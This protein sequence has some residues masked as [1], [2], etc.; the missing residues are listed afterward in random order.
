M[1]DNLDIIGRQKVDEPGRRPLLIKRTDGLQV[2][3]KKD[4]RWWVPKASAVFLLRSPRVDGSRSDAVHARLFTEL[5]VDALNEYSYD[6]SIARLH[7]DVAPQANA[8]MLSVTGYNDK[9]AVL[10][11]VV[12]EH[13]R[14][15]V[16]DPQ[17][18]ELVRDQLRQTYEN[19]NL[20]APSA[21]ASY[22][23]AYMTVQTMY[24]PSEQLESL[25]GAS[26]LP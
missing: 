12:V 23:S 7:F 20:A 2:W 14:T 1:P 19:F 11:K 6:A 26:S 13:L 24:L 25:K 4:D 3:H 16:I 21:H 5:V 10:L 18:F 15:L 8:L 22:R 17:R 9:L